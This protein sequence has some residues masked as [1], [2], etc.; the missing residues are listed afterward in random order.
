MR[1]RVREK[2]GAEMAAKS[3]KD[4]RESLMQQLISK[5]AD[6]AH[7]EVLIDDYVEYFGLVKKM[8]ADIRKNGLSYTAISAAGKEYEKDNPSVKMLPQY[9]RSMLSILKELG[10]TTDHVA[11]EDDEL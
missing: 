4:I 8:K 2:K 9:T 6:V 7:F 3:K 11:E 10:L 1:A 5:G